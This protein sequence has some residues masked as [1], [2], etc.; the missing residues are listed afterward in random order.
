M[1]DPAPALSVLP[2]V[3]FVDPPAEYVRT[4]G[5][6]IRVAVAQAFPEGADILVLGWSKEQQQ[7]VEDFA[8]VLGD[9]LLIPAAA[10]DTLPE[11]EIQLQLL[12]RLGNDIQQ[13]VTHRVVVVEPI[14]VEEPVYVA[15]PVVGFDAPP[16]TYHHDSDLDLALSVVGPMPA[17]GDIVVVAWLEDAQRMVSDFSFTL[18][19][20]GG[21]V[22]PAERMEM[23][24]FGPVELQLLVRRQGEIRSVIVHKM[25]IRPATTGDIAFAR[26]T[27][28]GPQSLLAE[29]PKSTFRARAGRYRS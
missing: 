26:R 14:I 8:F 24:P 13:R 27:R 4:S 15:L 18:A 21:W 1:I 3:A 9:D 29:H 5:D 11:G 19:E 10:L 23:L 6:S 20:G 16:A 12:A 17:Q 7:M 2:E 22:I 28:S 25:E